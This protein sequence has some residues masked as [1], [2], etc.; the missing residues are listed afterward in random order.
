M[1]VHALIGLCQSY[2]SYLPDFRSSMLVS[3]KQWPSKINHQAFEYLMPPQLWQC[4]WGLFR[5]T[6]PIGDTITAGK[7]ADDIGKTNMTML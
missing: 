3:N 6:K 1:Q 5:S 2:F 7:D 4:Q